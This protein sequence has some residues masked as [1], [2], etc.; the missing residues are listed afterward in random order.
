[1]PKIVYPDAG[2]NLDAE[3]SEASR[4]KLDALGGM[5]VHYGRPES[6]EAYVRRIGDARAILLG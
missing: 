5:A 4:R 1:M 6:D 2:E 3:L